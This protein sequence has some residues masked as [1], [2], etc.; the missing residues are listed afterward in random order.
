MRKRRQTPEKVPSALDCRAGSGVAAKRARREVAT[1][2]AAALE[3]CALADDPLI[4][5]DPL[6]SDINIIDC[7]TAE[8]PA[9]V[10]SHGDVLDHLCRERAASDAGSERTNNDEAS[11]NI[12]HDCPII[13]WDIFASVIDST[14]SG[15]AARTDGLTAEA[16]QLA[17]MEFKRLLWR[18]FN[19]RV[20]GDGSQPANWRNIRGVLFGEK[21]ACATL[22]RSAAH[23]SVGHAS[24]DVFVVACVHYP[25]IL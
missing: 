10:G 15:R 4:V 5:A 7:E 8:S 21:A 25:P 22:D 2:A 14:M 18:A 17:P 11:R 6:D 19:D 23:F 16:V 20:C 3:L 12:S 1:A 24:D 13:P 9:A